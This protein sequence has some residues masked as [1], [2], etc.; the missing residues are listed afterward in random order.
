MKSN[1]YEKAA[2]WQI[3]K[4][5]V[6]YMFACLTGF[7]FFS[8]HAD[9]QMSF[10][11]LLQN[12]ANTLTAKSQV[13]IS[14]SVY[15]SCF[16]NKVVPFVLMHL[17]RVNF[18]TSLVGGR[19]GTTSEKVQML[20]RLSYFRTHTREKIE[21]ENLRWRGRLHRCWRGAVAAGCAGRGLASATFDSGWDGPQTFGGDKAVF[22]CSLLLFDL[23]HLSYLRP[24][25]KSPDWELT[26]THISLA[27]LMKHA[28]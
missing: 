14:A 18:F 8:L 20:L 27:S 4:Q 2:K 16:Q 7:S 6:F 5:L 12:S 9:F 26:N 24:Y 3:W 17:G 1:Q 11:R 13:K 23:C 28:C 21:G 15:N 25:V 19:G 22:C 10:H